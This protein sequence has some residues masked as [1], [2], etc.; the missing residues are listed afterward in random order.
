MGNGFEESLRV[1][2]TLDCYALVDGVPMVLDFK[3]TARV[4]DNHL[5]QVAAYRAMLEELGYAVEAAGVV[6]LPRDR[7][8]AIPMHVES[9]TGIYLEVFKAARALH[10]AQYKMTHR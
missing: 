5:I 3:T 10:E 8:C 9:D 2:G 7:H 4:Y 6:P 1:G